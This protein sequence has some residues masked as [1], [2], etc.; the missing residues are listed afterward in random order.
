MLTLHEVLED[1]RC[2]GDFEGMGSIDVNTRGASG[3]TPLH[4]IATLGD[5]PAA[6]LLLDAGAEI[7]AAD[8]SG[9]TP[10]H[11]AVTLGHESLVLVLVSRGASRVAKDLQGDTPESIAN[12]ANAARIVAALQNAA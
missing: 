5:V 9:R 2:S 8:D 10:L 3:T 12:A 6:Q 4:F 7:N 1:A 11:E